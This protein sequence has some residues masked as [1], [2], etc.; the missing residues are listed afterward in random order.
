MTRSARNPGTVSS[1]LSSFQIPSHTAG[2]AAIVRALVL[3]EGLEQQA[4]KRWKIRFTYSGFGSCWARYG[5]SAEQILRQN[6][7]ITRHTL[8]SSSLAHWQYLSATK[9]GQ[10]G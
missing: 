6:H 5:P 2:T 10:F 3:Q 8:E 9:C 4:L 7:G 1:Q